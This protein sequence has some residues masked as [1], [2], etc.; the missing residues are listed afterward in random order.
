MKDFYV[1]KFRKKISY[2]ERKRV[3]CQACQ[4]YAQYCKHFLRY[5]FFFF[6]LVTSCSASPFFFFFYPPSMY[7]Y[8]IHRF[9]FLSTLLS[10]S[11]AFTTLQLQLTLHISKLFFFFFR[12]YW[13]FTLLL[14]LALYNFI[15]FYVVSLGNFLSF[16]STHFSIFF[17][18]YLTCTLVYPLDFHSTIS[19]S[20]LL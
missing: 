9:Y 6:F 20:K 8:S 13:L 14:A 17:F 5:I 7:L 12:V 18:F 1:G 4:I 2:R 16:S 19:S 3:A 15:L 11:F 10:P